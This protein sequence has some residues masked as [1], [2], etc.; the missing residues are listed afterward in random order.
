[1]QGPEL[2]GFKVEEHEAPPPSIDPTSDAWFATP[3][4]GSVRR[5]STNP[6]PPLREQSLGD[7][8]GDPFADG[9]FKS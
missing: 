4:P 3:A 9:W 6:P 5:P 7:F 8:I 1:M 2:D